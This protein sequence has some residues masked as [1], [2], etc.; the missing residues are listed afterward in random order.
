MIQTFKLYGWKHSLLQDL[1][2]KKKSGYMCQQSEQTVDRDA[3]LIH[4]K[5]MTN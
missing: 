2:K 4:C 5:E 3:M 1:K